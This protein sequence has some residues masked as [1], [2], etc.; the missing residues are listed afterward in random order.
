SPE[1]IGRPWKRRER[2][3]SWRQAVHTHLAAIPL[4]HRLSEMF[5]ALLLA[6]IVATVASLL[7]CLFAWN[8]FR[9]ELFV[10]MAVVSTFA[11]WAI[12]TPAK[13]GE[14]WIE[15][16]APM[17]FT[18]LILGALVGVFAWGIAETTLLSLPHSH[19]FA[20]GVHDSLAHEFFGWNTY[21]TELIGH[22]S[23]KRVPLPMFAAYFAFLFAILRWWKL[24]ECVR[25]VRVSFWSILKCGLVAWLLVFVWWFPQPI[26]VLTA[27]VVAFSVQLSS[28]WLSPRRRREI[29]Q[30]LP[31]QQYV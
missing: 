15:D 8:P 29:V 14:G 17:R 4:R 1:K 23:E 22:S 3:Q 25:S 28:P 6:S 26:G 5:G 16:Q 21:D 2:H 13:I 18:Q 31:R 12:M 20:P 30:N 27:I 7:V 11:S 24:G 10:W 19:D 9:V